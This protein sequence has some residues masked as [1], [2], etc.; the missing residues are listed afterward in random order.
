MMVDNFVLNSSIF[1]WKIVERFNY[2]TLSRKM[3]VES[4]EIIMNSFLF[5]EFSFKELLISI[6]IF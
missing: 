3:D 5:A 2:E 1:D 6:K 4:L